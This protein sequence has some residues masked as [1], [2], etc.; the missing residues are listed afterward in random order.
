[1][2]DANN[3]AQSRDVFEHQLIEQAQ[4][5]MRVFDVAGKEVGKVEDVRMGDPSAV[6]DAGQ[7]HSTLTS[8]AAEIGRRIPLIMEDPDDVGP[9][10]PEPERS[11]LLRMGYIKVQ[12]GGI[13]GIG[14]QYRYVRADLI[15]DIV[16]DRIMLAVPADEL[17]TEGEDRNPLAA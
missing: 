3:S 5:G 9:T 7:E 15:S 16:G 17:P 6:T 14:S 2:M 13:L 12:A 1:M 10:V 8:G 4:E 11:N